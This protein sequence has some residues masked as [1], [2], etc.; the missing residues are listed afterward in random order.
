MTEVQHCSP[1]RTSP[2][3]TAAAFTAVPADRTVL[4]AVAVLAAVPVIAFGS[5]WGAWYL[6]FVSSALLGIATGGRSVRK[7]LTALLIVAAG[8]CGWGA[9]LL[10]RSL[11]GEPLA[12]TAR[13]VGALAG[14]P[15]WASLL[16]GTTLLIAL[17]QS[18][19]GLWLGRSAIGMVL[20][21]RRARTRQG[22]AG[23]DG[24]T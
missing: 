18:L 4:V 9:P 20:S 15:P 14:L 21:W 6:P 23:P 22:S 10:W 8:V 3:N 11:S 19:L 1:P 16:I 17:L 13:T 7:R 5:V 2:G 24:L 12:E